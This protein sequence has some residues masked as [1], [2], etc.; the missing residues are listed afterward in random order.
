MMS[1]A[2][3]VAPAEVIVRQQVLKS[4]VVR[5]SAVNAVPIQEKCD[6]SAPQ[7]SD[8]VIGIFLRHWK[9][10]TPPSKGEVAQGPGGLNAVAS[11]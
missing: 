7:D 1:N 10:G 5:A 6:L 11:D 4:N 2:G 3:T 8:P 9:R